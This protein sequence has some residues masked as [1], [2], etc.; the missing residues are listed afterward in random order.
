MR[1]ERGRRCYERLFWLAP[2]LSRSTVFWYCWRIG[3]DDGNGKEDAQI[4]A[5]GRLQVIDDR[6]K[7][8]R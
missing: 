3:D 5:R 4:S 1:R 7:M 8:Q 2:W 6:G